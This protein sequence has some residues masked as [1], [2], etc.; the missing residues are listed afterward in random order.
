M[1]RGMT[2]R[3]APVGVNGLGGSTHI[4]A[5]F[6]MSVPLTV[7]C[8]CG[9]TTETRF[10]HRVT[11]ICGREYDTSQI[12][13]SSYIDLRRMANRQ[14]LYV[15]LGIVLAIGIGVIT[16]LFFGIKGPALSVPLLAL[17]WWRIVLPRFQRGQEELLRS[18]PVVQLDAGESP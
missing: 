4:Y 6:S 16:F 18:V 11:C 13:D 12:P 1:E 7:R 8:E 9:H 17:F 10:G 2:L 3:S 15:R 5:P 14:R